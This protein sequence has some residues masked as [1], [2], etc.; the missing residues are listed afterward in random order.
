MKSQKFLFLILLMTSLAQLAL[1]KSVVVP[2][3][4]F[5]LDGTGS[6]YNQLT[7]GDTLFFA[8]GNRD[9]LCIKNFNGN[10]THPL[11]MINQGGDVIIDTDHYYGISVQ[12]CRYIKLTGTGD[13]SMMYGFKIDRVANGAGLSFCNLSSDFEA[14]H[15]SIQNTLIG[16]LYAKTDPDGTPSTDRAN[17]TQYN[18]IIHDLYIAHTA[19]EGM[20]I[21]STKFDG[22]TVTVNGVATLLY[23]SILDG[24]KVYNNIIEY[25]GWDGIQVS[26]ASRNCQIYNNT[27][28]FDSQAGLDTQMSGIMLGGGTKADCFNNYIADGK[29]CGIEIHGLGGN[30]VFNNIIVNP[31]LNYYPGDQNWPKHGMYVSDNSVQPD[32]SFYIFNNT[33]IN[34]KSDG[35]RFNSIISKNNLISSNVIINPGSY[36]YYATGNT[37]FVGNDSY[38]MA[39]NGFGNIIVSNNYFKRDALLAGF[40]SANLHDAADFALTSGSPLIDAADTNPKVSPIF[41]F[42]N[43]PRPSGLKSDIGAYEFQGA[44]IV[45]TGGTI[46]ANQSICPG[47]ATAPLTSVIAPGGFTGTPEYKWQFS[48]TNETSGFTD[49]PSTN[50]NSYATGILIATTWFRRLAKITGS[51]DWTNAV[52]SN[53]VKVTVNVLPAAVAGADRSIIL[54]SS[55]QLGAAAVIGSSYSWTSSPAGFSSSLS[56]P[57]VTPLVNTVYTLTESNTVTGCANSHSVTVSM[58][59]LP[60]A[61]AGANRTICQNSST[62]IGAAATAGSTYSW[63]SSPAGFTSTLANPTVSPAVTTTYTL[64]ESNTSLGATSSHSV[65]VT[66]NPLPAANTGSNRSICPT[67]G[68]QIGAPQIPGNAYNW[69]SSPAGFTSTSSYPVVYPTLTTTYTLTETNPTTGCSNSNQVVVT[70][71]PLPAAGVGKDRAICSGTSTELGVAAVSGSTYSWS[72]TPAGFTSTL[73]NPTVAPLVNTIYNLVET[74]TATGC[75]WSHNVSVIVNK[76][77]DA[78][79]GANRSICQNSSTQIGAAAISGSGYSWT[80][81]PAGFTSTLAN[82]SVTPLVTTTY[83]LTETLWTTGCSSSHS[84]VITVNPMPFVA[85]IGGTKILCLGSETNLTDATAGGTWSSLTTSVVTVNSSGTVTGLNAGMATIQ[86]SVTNSDGCTANAVTI[87]TV[88]APAS[89]PGNFTQS[90]SSAK[91][92]QQNVVFTVPFVSGITYNWTYSGSGATISGSAN[93]VSLSFSK[94]ATPGTLSVTATNGCGT[95]VP[96]SINISLLKDGILPESS[97]PVNVEIPELQNMLIVYPNPTSGSATF[98]FQVSEDAKATLDIFCATGQLVARIFDENIKAG[99][100]HTVHFNQSLSSGVYPCILSWKGQRIPIKLIIRK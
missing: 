29:G 77:P 39:P 96:R 84:V 18:T 92:G 13:K 38:V 33:I 65:V 87:V 35:I 48:V 16:G 28:R 46:A 25:A 90:S 93:S 57:M 59:K 56:N 1:S 94:R 23:P 91:A 22:Q 6:P 9:Y 52:S 70:V 83:T 53:V 45:Y 72:S 97:I 80:S 78:V 95:S 63:I 62:Q 40:A 36:T 21:G 11:V 67:S 98:D 27:I 10:A 41:D 55:T 71:N 34:P 74:V 32:S 30:R 7:G 14:D 100:T 31:G 4:I 37:S 81:S 17:F 66:V 44:L 54:N 19:D 50:S 24:V 2:V 85:V 51:L 68:I 20:Y 69:T 26:S 79:V 15:I 82:P 61:L 86:Y 88:N 43:H 12:N 42:L 89:Q 47:N 49:I 76:L 75:S 5:Y 60:D 8:A 58:G 99:N 3:S 73:A 64:T